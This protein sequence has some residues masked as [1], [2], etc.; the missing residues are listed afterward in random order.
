M[1]RAGFVRS[2][3]VDDAVRGKGLANRGLLIGYVVPQKFS[4][5]WK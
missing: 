5:K 3:M 2:V 1:S 4:P